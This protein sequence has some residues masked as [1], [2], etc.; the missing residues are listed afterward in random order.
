MATEYVSAVVDAVVK[1]EALYMS[2][3]ALTRDRTLAPTTLPDSGMVTAW[4]CGVVALTGFAF[5]PGMMIVG[6]VIVVLFAVSNSSMR[7]RGLTFIHS[8]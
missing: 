8:R 4:P 7:S 3:V 6:L 5:P 1:Q 2:Q